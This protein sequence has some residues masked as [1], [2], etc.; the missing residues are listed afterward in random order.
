VASAHT[1]S[2]RMSFGPEPGMREK[3]MMRRVRRRMQ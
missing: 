3:K 1:Q 2:I